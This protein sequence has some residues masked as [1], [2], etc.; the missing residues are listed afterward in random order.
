M[1]DIEDYCMG[2]AYIWHITIFQSLIWMID[3]EHDYLQ[4][5]IKNR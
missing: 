5:M 2:K 1:I 3:I 4:I